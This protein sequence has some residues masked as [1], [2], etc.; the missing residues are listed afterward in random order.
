[1]TKT[2]AVIGTKTIHKPMRA[3]LYARVSSQKQKDEETIDSQIDSLRRYAQEKGYTINEK[4]IFLDNGVSGS[5]LQRSALDELRDMICFE[6]IEILLVYAPDRL[7][8]NYTHQL[9]LMEEFKKR[10]ISVCFL[11]NP[12]TENTPEAKM[13]QHF[14]GIFAEYERA[15]I[16]DRSRRGRIYKAKQGDPSVIPNLPYG[17]RKVKREN[18][19][20]I[21]I[22]NEEAVIVKEIYRIYLYEAQSLTYVAQKITSNGIS[23]RKGGVKWDRSSIRD[24]LKNPTYTGTAHFGKTER[25]DGSSDRIRKHGSKVY[26]KAKYARKKR[27]ED[28]WL[29]INVPPIISETDFEQVQERLKQN[30]I[31]ASRNTKKPS[32]LQGLITCGVCG[33]PFYKRIRKNG[34]NSL[35]Y[36]YCRGQTSKSQKKCSNKAV[37]QEKIDK[38][39]F[40]EVLK[41]LYNPDL[42]E[43]ELYR[44]AR[45]TSNTTEIEQHEITLKKEIVKLSN[46]NDR[47]LDAYQSGIVE[48]KELKKRSCEIDGRRKGFE[49]DLKNLQ[50]L[51]FETEN[52]VE[53]SDL[54]GKI[55]KRMETKG[56]NLSLDEKRK[57]TRL[58]VEQVVVHTNKI[59]L[60]HCVSPMS[61][62]QEECLFRAGE[63]K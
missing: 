62:A 56:N 30:K 12:P 17:Y 13:F 33:Q 50:A 6:P 14:Q 18:A 10:G 8:R 28:E 7:S 49:K 24:I 36:Y 32:L 54:F 21:E 9:I 16:L 61:L 42:V 52:R 47:L 55:L 20:S 53:F 46:E 26:L 31:F 2:L 57:L 3:A 41:L 44:R 4:F 19:I 34:D 35:G 39:V 23:P 40:A 1:M 63:V 37:R 22:V 25:S 48:L 5:T 38:L 45:E 51:K 60:V 15:L 27:P 43:Q 59:E 29:P 11:K 58:L